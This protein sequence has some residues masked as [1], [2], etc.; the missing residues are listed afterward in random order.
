MTSISA[1]TRSQQKTEQRGP[2]VEHVLDV[3]RRSSP[4][5]LWAR[6]DRC[7]A[8]GEERPNQ[9]LDYVDVPLKH[10]KGG[11]HNSDLVQSGKS[12]CRDR[13]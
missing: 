9:S 13:K 2:V 3:R 1:D 4:K 10:A 8:G 11:R 5:I 6:Q 7:E 12:V